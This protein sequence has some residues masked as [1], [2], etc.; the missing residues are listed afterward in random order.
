VAEEI[1]RFWSGDPL[2]TPDLRRHLK[3]IGHTRPVLPA[4]KAAELSRQRLRFVAKL[5]ATAGYAG[6]VILFD[7][8]ELIGRY[9]LLQRGKAYAEL[10]RW[11]AGDHG[12]PAVP[13]AAVLAM[14]GDFE[15]AVIT[16]KGDREQ[17]PARLRG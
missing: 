3:A 17:V 11:V 5:L 7:E 6:W 12:A 13:I 9:S 2:R 10:A 16:E 1:V 14:T 15:A 8:V 4:V